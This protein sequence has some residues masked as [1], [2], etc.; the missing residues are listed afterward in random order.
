MGLIQ[1]AL[2]SSTASGGVA[3]GMPANL[4]VINQ[5]GPNNGFNNATETIP[6]YTN[7]PYNSNNNPNYQALSWLP[8]T[9]G[10]YS[11][12]SYR[13]YRNGT[14]YDTISSPRQITGYIA[15][16]SPGSDTYAAGKLTVTALSGGTT[17]IA[18]GDILPG[19]QLFSSASGFNVNTVVNDY[20]GGNTG[21]GGTGNYLVN[22]SQTVGSSGSQQTFNTWTY[23]D[24]AATG[25]CDATYRTQGTPYTYT[26]SAVDSQGNEGSQAT[27]NVYLFNGI[28]YV[29][30]TD[31]G[32]GATAY[33]STAVTPSSAGPYV[34]KSTYTTGGG[35]IPFPVFGGNG[36]G[37][38]CPPERFE[39]AAFTGFTFDVMVTDNTWQTN[40]LLFI[41]VMRAA[42]YN[43]SGDT[44][45]WSQPNFWSFGSPVVNT[46]TTIR[47][48]FSAIAYGQ[49]GFTAS[50]VGTAQYTGTLTVTS[51]Q[52]SGCAGIDGSAWVHQPAGSGSTL[53]NSYI[54]GYSQA[55][56]TGTYTVFGPNI[57][58]SENITSRSGWVTQGTSAYK[59][60]FQWQTNTNTVIYW[61]KV[62]LYT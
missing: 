40:P 53:A 49:M 18:N 11:I 21:G 15:P 62:G 30:A 10:T 36:L 33:N 24:T 60:A 39:I 47:V 42:G 51:F 13:I 57:T 35:D 34:M 54:V 23:Q 52:S 56:G 37:C 44:N 3:P 16:Q 45:H 58:G 46:W 9:P 25:C 2:L 55:G 20:P 61:D 5:G 50:F 38:L 32:G 19:A 31:F 27:P 43:N 17:S 12:A 8:A 22:F 48:P 29:Q 28:S 1:Q 6:G 7:Q 4:Q 59:F 41:S 26:V 14:L